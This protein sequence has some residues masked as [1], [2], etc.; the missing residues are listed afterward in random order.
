MLTGGQLSSLS[1][2]AG[3]VSP[4]ACDLEPNSWLNL[5]P[6]DGLGVDELPNMPPPPH[7]DSSAPAT[8]SASVAGARP[9]PAAPIIGII[10]LSGI[11]KSPKNSPRAPERP[12]ARWRVITAQWRRTQGIPGRSSGLQQY[13]ETR[14]AAEIL[15]QQAEQQVVLPDAIDAEIAP[16]Q[17]LAGE[18]AFLQHPDRGRIGGNAG[19][20]DAVQIEFAEQRRQQ[21][22]QRRGHVAAMGVR[23][24]D[25][26]SDGA[27]LYDAAA[28][29]GERDAPDHRA[30][31][32]PE[33]DERI[34]AVGG[35][36][37]GIAAQPPPEARPGQVVGRPDRL[38]RRQIFPA[39][40]AQMRPLQKV[41]HLR[42]TQQQAL[43]ARG[44]CGRS[45]GWKPKQGHV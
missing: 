7:P 41:G 44:K 32:L 34:G 6:I 28:D 31:G 38:P 9:A 13:R 16:R 14:L 11:R 33:H 43:P 20:L 18:A 21:H 19:G 1:T 15:M 39:V 12:L 27:G 40:F 25:P 23:L 36:V 24:P 17:T 22:P 37:L 10:S 2:G 8:A 3:A 42:R 45:A 5:S 26:V 30:I 29:I 35:D 4:T